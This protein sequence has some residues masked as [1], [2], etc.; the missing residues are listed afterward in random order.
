[1][2]VVRRH[3][4]V[5][6]PVHLARLQ[7]LH[8]PACPGLRRTV[9]PLLAMSNRTQAETTAIDTPECREAASP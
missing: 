8:G 4:G 6:Q 1:M 2:Q 9:A 3:A 7:K 5:Q